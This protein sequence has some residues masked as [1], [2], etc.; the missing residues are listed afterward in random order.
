MSS[1]VRKLYRSRSDRIISG[2]CGGLGQFFGIDST[3]LRIIF[4]LLAIFGGSGIIIYLVMWLI[5]P[6]EPLS[7]ISHPKKE[8]IVPAEPAAE[9]E[10]TDQSE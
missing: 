7:S 3:L 2:V 10:E 9:V 8:D 4:V 1:E 6:E 5:V